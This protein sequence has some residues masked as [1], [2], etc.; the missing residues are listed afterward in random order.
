MIVRTRFYGPTDHR[1]SR[2]RVSLLDPTRWGGKF[3]PVTVPYDHSARNA[4]DAATVEALARW[5]V[6]VTPRYA[7]DTGRDTFYIVDAEPFYT[8]AYPG[9]T[10]TDDCFR[11]AVITDD[12]G[13]VENV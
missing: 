2:F 1:G 3:L 8:V 7:D 13:T 12:D 4:A 11:D 9:P 5:G 6:T 10:T